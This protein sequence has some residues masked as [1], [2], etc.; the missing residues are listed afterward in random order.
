MK[1]GWAQV[2]L[3]EV[4]DLNEALIAIAMFDMVGRVEVHGWPIVAYGEGSVSK[5]ASSKV[6]SIFP[7][8]ELR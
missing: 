8:M 7:L 2:A 6:V 3:G 5:A 4:R 1:I